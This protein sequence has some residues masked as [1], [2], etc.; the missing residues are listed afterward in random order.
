M[1]VNIHTCGA[2][3]QFRCHGYQIVYKTPESQN[4]MRNLSKSVNGWH[5]VLVGIS[6]CTTEPVPTNRH[7]RC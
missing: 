7:Y 6:P 1:G 2:Q 3:Y 4:R 5:D